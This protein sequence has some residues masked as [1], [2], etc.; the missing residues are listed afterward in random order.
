MEYSA[1]NDALQTLL[2]V[3]RKSRKD[4]FDRNAKGT[5]WIDK[6]LLAVLPEEWEEEND[7]DEIDNDD[8]TGANPSIAARWLIR[9]LGTRHPDEFIKAANDIGMP[10]HSQ[11][12]DENQAFAMFR[13]ANI[14]VRGAWIIRKHFLA[15]FGTSFLASE[16]KV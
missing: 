12:I 10:I 9:F 14:G 5:G 6:L 11:P 7:E 15:H 13:D 2:Q 8:E 4:L 3:P 16:A 1:Y